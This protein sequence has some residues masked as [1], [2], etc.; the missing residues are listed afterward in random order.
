MALSQT[1]WS[2]MNHDLMLPPPPMIL[3]SQNAMR[4]VDGVITERRIRISRPDDES[5][6]CK[7]SR[8]PGLHK[9]FSQSTQPPTTSSTSNAISPQQERTEHSGHR[10]C[11]YGVKLSSRRNPS[12]EQACYKPN[13]LI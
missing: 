2:Q 4:A 11:K 6:R 12:C 13:W 3:E 8:V 9:D 5:A 7:V 10:L 1:N